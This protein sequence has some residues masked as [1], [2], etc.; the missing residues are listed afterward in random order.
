MHEIKRYW[1]VFDGWNTL[2]EYKYGDWCK[3]EDVEPL[4]QRIAEL[5][6]EAKTNF[7]LYQDMGRVH[8]EEMGKLE[9]ELANL[10]LSHGIESSKVRKLEKQLADANAQEPALYRITENALHFTSFEPV[11]YYIEHDY[12][13][14]K[15][16]A[17]PIP[18][19]AIPA[20]LVEWANA[21]PFITDATTERTMGYEKARAFVRAQLDKIGDV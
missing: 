20:E 15:F 21:E 11:K 18:A 10:Q 3:Y 2:E 6:A 16:Y 7:D 17:K 1:R 12:S 14:K 9:A 5:E 8:V 13:V 4:I 19:P